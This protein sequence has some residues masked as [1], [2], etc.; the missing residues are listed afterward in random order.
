MVAPDNPAAE[1]NLGVTMWEKAEGTRGAKPDSEAKIREYRNKAIEHWRKAVRIRPAFS[2]ALNNLGCACASRRGLRRRG[3]A[4][5]AAIQQGDAKAAATSPSPN[6]GSG[7]QKQLGG[8]DV[9]PG[10]HPLQTRTLRRAQQPGVDP[11]AV[12]ETT[13][14]G[15]R[16]IHRGRWSCGPITPMPTS[17]S[18]TSSWRW[19]RPP[20]SKT[21]RRKR[22]Q[23]LEEAPD[24]VNKVIHLGRAQCPRLR[25]AGPHP[26]DAGKA[27]G[28]GPGPGA[29]RPG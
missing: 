13:G 29:G 16:G 15:D 28:G 27:A 11:L 12:D 14:R 4:L 6:A 19:P 5:A 21:S 22:Q 8:G 17:P 25:A 1:N 10:G 7:L 23:R 26:P 20:P 2:D 18:P 9:L 24:H 3:R